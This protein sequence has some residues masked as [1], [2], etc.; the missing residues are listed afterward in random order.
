MM[1][2][3]MV[4]VAVF[5]NGFILGRITHVKE[6]KQVHE[7]LLIHEGILREAGLIQDDP[8]S[9]ENSEERQVAL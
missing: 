4:F 5:L 7:M 9:S 2:T 8:E 1:M 6:C 3:I